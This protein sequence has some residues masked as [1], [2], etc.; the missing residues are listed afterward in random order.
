MAQQHI[1]GEAGG[2]DH[3][4]D[5]G[6]LHGNGSREGGE[7]SGGGKEQSGAKAGR[8]VYHLR[9]VRSASSLP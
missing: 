6:F 3:D 2:L 9:P 5:G 7:G 1:A 8:A 4:G